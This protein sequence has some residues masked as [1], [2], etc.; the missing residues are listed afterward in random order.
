M[1]AESAWCGRDALAERVGK[2]YLSHRKEIFRFLAGQG[3][4]AATAQD[5]TQD[6]FLK[7]LVG[8]RDG[9][10]VTSEQ[11]WLYR[12]AANNVVDYWRRERRV[13]MVKLDNPLADTLQSSERRVDERVAEE[14]R[15][16]RLAEAIRLLSKEHRMCVLL[17]SQGMR[18][19]E[20]ACI[21]GVGVSTAADWLAIAVG[22]LRRSA[23][24]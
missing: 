4:P 20:I 23:H 5:I 18:Y 2:L 24:E 13:V 19:R 21:L 1:I 10:H 8:L 9:A 6:V 15:M 16:R 17:R 7:L 11:A 14:E 12:V 22:R 3:V